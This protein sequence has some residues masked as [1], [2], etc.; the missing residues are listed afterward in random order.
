MRGSLGRQGSG[1][2]VQVRLGPGTVGFRYDRSCDEQAFPNEQSWLTAA[3]AFN[4]DRPWHVRGPAGEEAPAL[5][6]TRHQRM[7]GR[8]IRRNRCEPRVTS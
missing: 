8:R 4:A 3:E 7:E 6:P 5:V 2:R 1:D